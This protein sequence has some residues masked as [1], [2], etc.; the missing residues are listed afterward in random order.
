[1]RSLFVRIAAG[2]LA[3]ASFATLLIPEAPVEDFGLE[4]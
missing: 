4:D 3:I 1:M 2:G